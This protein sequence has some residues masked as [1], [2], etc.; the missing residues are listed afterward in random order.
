M[1]DHPMNL[2]RPMFTP[3][4]MLALTH[5][6]QNWRF[7]AHSVCKSISGWPG[8]A[9]R[10]EVRLHAGACPG[11]GGFGSSLQHPCQPTHGCN[12]GQDDEVAP[13]PGV[14]VHRLDQG[15]EVFGVRDHRVPFWRRWACVRAQDRV[16]GTITTIQSTRSAA[17]ALCASLWRSGAPPAAG[18]HLSS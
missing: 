14:D 8:V 6:S 9:K 17:R 3:V 12:H 7:P 15:R 13:A 10:A 2:C 16:H 11:C 4:S 5:G 18:R 1:I